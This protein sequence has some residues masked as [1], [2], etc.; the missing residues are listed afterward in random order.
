MDAHYIQQTVEDPRS[1]SGHH[2][3]QNHSRYQDPNIKPAV[4]TVGLNSSTPPL[5]DPNSHS[6]PTFT[7][8]PISDQYPQFQFSQSDAQ[9]TDSS[10]RS[11]TTPLLT[12]G[13]SEQPLTHQH[14][15]SLSRSNTYPATMRFDHPQPTL[16]MVAHHPT[17]TVGIQQFDPRF[18]T[19][20]AQTYTWPSEFNSRHPQSK[21]D[22]FRF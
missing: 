6:T 8:S 10:G 2:S 11:R 19:G 14:P 17:S 5:L 18:E 15:P 22:Q 3:S 1:R 20:V 13:P 4:A 12:L 16:Q 21:A 9:W 7:T